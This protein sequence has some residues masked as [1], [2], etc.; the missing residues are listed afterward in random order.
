M[1]KYKQF[2]QIRQDSIKGKERDRRQ[3]KDRKGG[4]IRIFN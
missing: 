3:N 4:E 1:D 2:R